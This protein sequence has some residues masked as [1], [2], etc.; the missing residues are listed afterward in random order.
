MCDNTFFEK[1]ITLTVKLL[2]SSVEIPKKEAD[3]FLKKMYQ[4]GDVCK[5]FFC[6]VLV[7]RKIDAFLEQSS[8][9]INERTYM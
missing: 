1:E 4:N 3:F 6:W 8:F 5:E 2:H 9:W 7:E